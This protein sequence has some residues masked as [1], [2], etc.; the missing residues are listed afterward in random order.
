MEN[1]LDLFGDPFGL[2]KLILELEK[3]RT[4]VEQ[5]AS[6]SDPLFPSRFTP[7]NSNQS[8]N[9]VVENV[10]HEGIS[11]LGTVKSVPKNMSPSGSKHNHVDSLAPSPKPINDFFI[12]ERFQEFISI[13]QAIGLG[14]K[15]KKQWVKTLCHSNQVNFLSLQE[16]KMVSFDVFV[17]TAFW[18]NMLF[19]FVTSSACGRS[20]GKWLATDSELLFMSVYSPQDMPHKRQLW[21]YMMGIINRW[22]G[23]VIVMGD[24]NEVCFASEQHG[25]TFYASNAAKFNTL[26]QTLKTWSIQKKSIRKHDHRVLQDYLLEIDSR[27]NKGE[28][29]YED[30]PNRAKTFHD[31][32]IIDR[33]ISVDLAQKAKVKWAIEGVEKSNFFH[34]IVMSHPEIFRSIF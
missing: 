8:R 26:K 28:G 1:S 30:L 3:K 15:E 12:L 24:F 7:W 20:G 31:I 16:T 5:T 29:L 21:A 19:D 11:S 32:G 34:G 23:E 10:A 22:H 13:G 25:S 27:L 18:G 2:E 9:E 33:K 4:N 17:V 6:G 14:G